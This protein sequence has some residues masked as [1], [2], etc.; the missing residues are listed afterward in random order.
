LR[1]QLF[2]S[3]QKALER[4][5]VHS[6]ASIEA[7]WISLHSLIGGVLVA[8]SLLIQLHPDT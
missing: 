6:A 1:S 3:R 5:A 7:A 8:K 2:Q 4:G